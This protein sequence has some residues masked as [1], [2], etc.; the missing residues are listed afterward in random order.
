MHVNNILK[1]KLFV[2]S[3]S[4][5]PTDTEKEILELIAESENLGSV[6]KISLVSNGEDYDSYKLETQEKNFLIKVSLDKKLKT[7]Q[8]EAQT[9]KLLSP[10]KLAPQF[11]SQ[12]EVKFG[13]KILYLVSSF[14]NLQPASE[15]GVSVLLF[16]YEAILK[17]IL[18]SQKYK[19]ETSLKEKLADLF[20]RTTFGN[21]P[22]FADL[23]SGDSDNYKLLSDEIAGLKSWI[24]DNYTDSFEG[25]GL[26]H[27]G[28][29]PSNLLLG[30][31]DMKIINW[32]DSCSGHSFIELSNLR[33]T[34]DYSQDFEYKVFESHKNIT[35]AGTWDEYLQVRN[36][37]A[38]VSL[39]DV[40][41]SYVKEIY[42]YRSLRS[43]KIL[44][45]FHSFCRNMPLFE[46]I[47]AFQKN[48]EKLTELFS[49][50]MV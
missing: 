36:F 22:E 31:R 2:F 17:R 33:M 10:E 7:F 5:Q 12:G 1:D 39:L 4:S 37:W 25:K 44:K 32:Q 6:K 13:D 14:E 15:F 40:V 35:S 47:P 26:I 8:K 20:E 38:G 48:K 30:A 29:S 23:I 9:L 28:I 42:L 50:P 3:G 21:Y 18:S 11:I 24:Q 45:T 46:H 19:S 34:F 41:F 27:T 49:S 43:D 16:N